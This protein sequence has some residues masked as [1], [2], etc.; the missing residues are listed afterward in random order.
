MRNDLNYLTAK[1]EAIHED[2]KQLQ[3]HVDEL[4]QEA[5]GRKAVQRFLL[6]SMSAMGVVV[7]W[8]VNTITNIINPTGG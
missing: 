1:L 4:R 3:I 2:V 7:G 8:L 5:A 6:A